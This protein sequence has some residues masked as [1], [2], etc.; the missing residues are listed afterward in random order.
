MYLRLGQPFF[1]RSEFV[2]SSLA[3]VRSWEG[4]EPCGLDGAGLVVRRFWM[5]GRGFLNIL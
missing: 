4:R 1:R 5:L 2:S 3:A